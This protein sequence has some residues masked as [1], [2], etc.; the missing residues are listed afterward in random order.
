MGLTVG[1]PQPPDLQGRRLVRESPFT[2][3]L[4]GVSRDARSEQKP[5]CNVERTRDAKSR[6][7][8]GSEENRR[9]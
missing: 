7:L 2:I 4:Q 6:P 8:Y 1:G 3:S 9:R 5:D